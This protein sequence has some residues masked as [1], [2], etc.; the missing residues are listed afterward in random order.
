M[1]SH[2][3][4]FFV[5]KQLSTL[6]AVFKSTIHCYFYHMLYNRYPECIPTV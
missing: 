6:L 1:L 3:L 2:I 5:G 4:V